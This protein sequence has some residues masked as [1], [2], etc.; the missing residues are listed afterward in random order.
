M[1]NRIGRKDRVMKYQRFTQDFKGSFIDSRESSL[2]IS[3]L[4]ET[5][6]GPEIASLR[7]KRSNLY[8]LNEPLP[9]R[10]DLNILF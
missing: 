10:H 6:F 3:S 1:I 4:S 8:F 9:V 7:A 2:S 5:L